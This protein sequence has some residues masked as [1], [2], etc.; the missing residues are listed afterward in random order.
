M[1]RTKRYKYMVFPGADPSEMLFD[2]QSDPGEMKN[3]AGE[4]AMAGELQR[5]RQLLAAWK[6]TTEEGKYPVPSS[7]SKRQGRKAKQATGRK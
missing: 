5:H 3:L 7:G 6:A 2:L 1:V 4:A